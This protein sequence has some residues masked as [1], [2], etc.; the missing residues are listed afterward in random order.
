MHELSRTN[1]STPVP[2]SRGDVFWRI[3]T[4]ELT[5]FAVATLITWAHTLDEMRIG[6]FIAVPFGVANLALVGVWPRLRRGWRAAS[7]IIFGLFWGLAVIPYHVL[8]LLEGSLYG[9]HISG[10]SRVVGGAAMVVLGVAIARRRG[11]P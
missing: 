10:L 6:E 11:A 8:P 1:G 2:I 3:A 9:Q 4:H 7:S 5:L